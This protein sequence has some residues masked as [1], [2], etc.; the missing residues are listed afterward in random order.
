MHRT[1][2]PVF[3]SGIS[4]R[5]AGENSM[6]ARDKVSS[7]GNGLTHDRMDRPQSL[8]NLLE[9]VEGK[10][11]P[12]QLLSIRAKLPELIEQYQTDPGRLLPLAQVLVDRSAYDDADRIFGVLLDGLPA[13]IK[14]IEGYALSAQRRGDRQEACKRWLLA[15][16]T[17]P[18]HP[19]THAQLARALLIA[20]RID[21]AGSVLSAATRRFP[22]S[23]AVVHGGAELAAARGDWAEVLN[24]CVDM[25]ERFPARVEGYSLAAQ[26]LGN[27][28]RLEEAE[29]LLESVRSRFGMSYSFMAASARLATRRGKWPE[30]FQ[31]WAEIR[32]RFPHINIDSAVGEAIILWRH[33]EAEG[34]PVAQSVQLPPELAQRT[35]LQQNQPRPSLNFPQAEAADFPRLSDTELMTRFESLGD[36]CEFGL[37]QRHFSSEP[38]GLLR[39]SNVS[40]RQLIDLLECRFEGVG[41]LENTYVHLDIRSGEYMIGDRRFFLMHSFLKLGEISEEEVLRKMIQR[42]GYLRQNIT[43]KLEQG[44]KIFV[45][46]KKTGDL[47]DIETSDIVTV[48]SK[49]F[50]NS[51][52]LLV[53]RTDIGSKVGKVEKFAENAMFGFVSSFAHDLR[54]PSIAFSEWRD[55]CASALALHSS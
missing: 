11:D 53:R 54:L 47:T 51:H 35:E 48:F 1:A 52:I 25:H 13:D 29:F 24:K 41:D 37:V 18:D 38:L 26:A 31:R 32:S 34:D 15:R 17:F 55:V 46:R 4:N 9:A 22:D 2:C 40:P 10:I 39:W 42:T 49:N 7:C 28:G 33:A 3:Q 36:G 43:E 16:D 8:S 19:N 30:A 50:P 20:G 27:L 44:L 12:D 23:M 6:I 14:I 5:G 21:D 45:Y